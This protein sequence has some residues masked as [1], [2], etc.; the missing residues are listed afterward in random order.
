[1]LTSLALIFLFGLIF[2]APPVFEIFQALGRGGTFAVRACGCNG[3]FA[4]R[5]RR[6]A[7]RGHSHFRCAVVPYGRRVGLPFQNKAPFQRT[8]VLRA[9][10]YAE[11]DRTGG[12]RFC[13]AFYGAFLRKYRPHRRCA[14]HFNT[15]PLGAFLIDL[16]YKKLLTLNEITEKAFDDSE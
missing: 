12:N 3:R 7:F 16:T 2:G 15:A 11:S 14:R 9:C 13:P 10:L 4:L 6:R 5:L 8:A 1:M